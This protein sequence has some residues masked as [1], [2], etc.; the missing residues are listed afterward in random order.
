M[1]TITEPGI[2]KYIVL[3]CDRDYANTGLT[4]GGGEYLSLSLILNLRP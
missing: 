1:I 3:H 2:D 4:R